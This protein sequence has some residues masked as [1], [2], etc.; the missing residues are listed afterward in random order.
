MPIDVTALLN[1]SPIS[2]LEL[3]ELQ[4]GDVVVLSHK[5]TEPVTIS[6]AGHDLLEGNVG[7]HN[8]NVALSITR[9]TV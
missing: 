2:L 4:P 3:A 1:A 5:A 6:A 9:W 7:Q 8:N